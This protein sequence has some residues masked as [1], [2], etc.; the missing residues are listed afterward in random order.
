M[1]AFCCHEGSSSCRPP[2][3]VHTTGWDFF[4]SNQQADACASDVSFE[5]WIM[6]YELEKSIL[7]GTRMLA[8][9]MK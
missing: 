4:A 7:I 5:L 6:S 2:S 1:E 8:P 9:A 3:P